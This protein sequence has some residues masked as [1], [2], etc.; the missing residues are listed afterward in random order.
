L[1]RQSKGLDLP[2]TACDESHLRAT[3]VVCTRNRP[4]SLRRCLE[5]IAGLERAP[6]EVI[7][8]DNTCGDPETAATALEFGAVYT[9]EPNRGLS[10][11]RNCGLAQSHSEVVAY[12]DDDATPDAQ[13]LGM[14]LEPFKDT[15]VTT[16]TGRIITPQSRDANSAAHTARF[17]CNKDP[18]WFGIATFGGL[19]L[20][21]NMAFRREAC[22]GQQIFDER[23]G[24]GAPF[25]IAEENYAFALLLSK[26]YTAVY[27]PD[28]IVFH[29]SVR[30]LEIEHE[31]RNSIAFSM[32]LF[33]RFPGHRLELLRFLYRR[34]RHKP[35][36]W[37]RES[38]DPGEII[39]SGWRILL[40]AFFGAAMLFLRN[41][42]PIKK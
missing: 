4:A 8:V 35:L 40:T 32:L 21:S 26:G 16:V 11:A 22:V 20:G 15:K 39:T 23:L 10:R 42:K 6:D 2:R 37:P 3:I 7:V 41:R 34:L 14:M 1:A 31:A 28:A 18:E 5:G 24:R 36:A 33:S 19:G 9:I 17:L 29:P 25:E 38:P 12:L 27:L 13:W 30:P